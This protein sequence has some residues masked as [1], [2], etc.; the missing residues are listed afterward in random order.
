MYSQAFRVITEAFAEVSKD[1]DDADLLAE[2]TLIAFHA[3]LKK[4]LR[5]KFVPYKAEH[6]RTLFDGRTNTGIWYTITYPE[7]VWLRQ[8]IK[9]DLADRWDK[10]QDH[11]KVRAGVKSGK[12][13]PKLEGA[14]L[15]AVQSLAENALR[16][17]AR[18]DKDNERVPDDLEESILDWAYEKN[19]ISVDVTTT[20]PET[21][22]EDY[23]SADP[24]IHWRIYKG[25]EKIEIEHQGTN[26]LVRIHVETNVRIS[27]VDVPSDY[28]WRR[29]ASVQKVAQ[30]YLF[31]LKG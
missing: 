14:L 29:R 31:R 24:E 20:D 22:E 21:G 7:T 19:A 4:N 2:E 6:S 30:Q 5:D 23:E 13:F 16:E 26:M 17:E 1:A 25:A 15:K 18:L 12:A 27:R 11:P 28:E 8:N 3:G 10:V 9:F